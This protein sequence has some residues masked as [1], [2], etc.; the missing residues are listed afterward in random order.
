MTYARK[1]ENNKQNLVELIADDTS[2]WSVETVMQYYRETVQPIPAPVA[3]LFTYYHLHLFIQFETGVFVTLDSETLEKE[4]RK[5][6][7]KDVAF[8]REC[9]SLTDLE[10][11]DMQD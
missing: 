11:A 7:E 1:L 9:D 10:L 8:L 5:A 4:V 6:L 3:N 2:T